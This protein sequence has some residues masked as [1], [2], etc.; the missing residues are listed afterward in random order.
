MLDNHLEIDDSQ[1]PLNNQNKNVDE[2]L[3]AK[4]YM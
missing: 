4:K 2:D 3:E 1:K